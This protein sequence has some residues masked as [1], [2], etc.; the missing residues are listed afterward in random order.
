MAWLEWRILLWV[1]RK[2]AHAM[3][4][5]GLFRQEALDHLNAPEPLDELIEIT[6]LRGWIA[7]LGLAL[8][9]GS[10]LAWAVLGTLPVEIQGE[11]RLTPESGATTAQ[12]RLHAVLQ[13]PLAAN[14]AI[15]AGMAARISPTGV[16]PELYGF[17]E[18]R[19]SRVATSA[20][21]PPLAQ[22]EVALTSDV[23][24]ASGFRWTLKRQQPFH[25]AANTSCLATVILAERHPIA[26]LFARQNTVTPT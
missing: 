12:S 16:A 10:A 14:Q 19:V 7:W 26:L 6:P 13:V 20:T 21:N 9:F 2:M 8:L 11:G 15:K 23:Q 1:I 4:P 3:I 24:N 17:I 22:I 25:V 5:A 18:G